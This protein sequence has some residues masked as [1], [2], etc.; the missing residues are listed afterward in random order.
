MELSLEKQ[1]GLLK[2]MCSYLLL[3]RKQ[4]TPLRI[5]FALLVQERH[6]EFHTEGGS[7]KGDMDDKGNQTDFSECSN[8]ICKGAFEIL[9]ESRAMAME[10]NDLTIQMVANYE[11]NIKYE[12]KSA[13]AWLKEK[14][15]V[16]TDEIAVDPAKLS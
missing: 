13:R 9:K 11:L 8:E 15:L 12:G 1:Y 14:N 5:S 6:N 7:A 2:I 10:I 16:Q 3:E 4:D